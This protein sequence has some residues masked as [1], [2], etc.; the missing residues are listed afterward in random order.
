MTLTSEL[1]KVQYNGDDST[2]AFTIPFVFYENEGIKAIILSAAGV[3]TTQILD[4]DYTLSGGNG[5]AGTLTMT[6]APATGQTLTIKSDIDDT[7][8]TSLPLGGALAS[9]AIELRLDILTRLVQQKEEELSRTIK[10][11]ETTQNSDVQLSDAVTGEILFWKAD[12]SIT[13]GTI[14]EVAG[15]SASVDPTDTDTTKDKLVSNLLAKNWTLTTKGDLRA[16]DTADTRLAVGI[17]GQKLN[18]DTSA[19][20]GLAWTNQNPTLAKSGTYTVL[21]TDQGKLL[22][23]SSTSFTVTLPAAATAGD[24]FEVGF[25]HGGTSDTDL[26]TIDG[27]A[28]ET[29]DGSTTKILSQNDETVWLVSDGSNW[30]IKNAI[31]ASSAA[32]NPA[33]I[34]GLQLSNGTDATNDIDVAVGACIN[35]TDAENMVLGSVLVKQIDAVWVAG[36]AAGGFPSALTLT[37][38][39]W[40][41]FFL[42]KNSS[43]GVVDAGFDTSL[44]ATNL[45][46]DATGYTLFRR[47]GSI[48]RATALNKLFFQKANKFIWDVGSLDLSGAGSL[49]GASLTLLTPTGLVCRAIIMAGMETNGASVSRFALVTPLNIT[50]TAPVEGFSNIKVLSGNGNDQQTNTIEIDT[51]TSS[52]VRQRVSSA[53]THTLEFVTEGWYDYRGQN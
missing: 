32:F 44:T 9:T 47:L 28:S 25:K 2:T 43:T 31:T 1:T 45:L 46:S 49:A 7:Q 21:V 13:S 27:N 38:D 4:T 34:N 30:H 22:L 6:T 53:A 40:Y 23:L 51:D 14:T 19:S 50:N 8:D 5:I 11:T 52:A 18:P 48:R 33:F 17:E 12:G 35:S 10:L 41:H 3:E 24:G 39:T 15:V 42:I 26:Y 36:S 37:N 29:I 20:P 16:F